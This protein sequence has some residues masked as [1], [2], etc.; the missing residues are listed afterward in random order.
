MLIL[1][2]CIIIVPFKFLTPKL[3]GAVF[4]EPLLAEALV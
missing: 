2:Y 3:L 1:Y 4:Q